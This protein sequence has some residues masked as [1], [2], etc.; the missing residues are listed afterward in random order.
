MKNMIKFSMIL[1]V[2]CCLPLSLKAAQTYIIPAGEFDVINGTGATA[3]SLTINGTPVSVIDFPNTTT[4]TNSPSNPGPA[5]TTSFTLPSNISL[6]N[7]T[8]LQFSFTSIISSSPVTGTVAL[9]ASLIASDGSVIPFSNKSVIN[10]LTTTADV[11]DQSQNTY[12]ATFKIAANAL[13]IGETY[14]LIVNRDNSNLNANFPTDIYLLAV[15]FAYTPI[16][17][18]N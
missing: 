4:S 6:S 1:V 8:N 3:T 2:L 14:Q 18:S 13:T 17:T 7:G 16:R 9:S 15:T 10:V 12:T 5:A 11:S